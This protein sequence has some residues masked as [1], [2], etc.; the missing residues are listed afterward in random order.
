VLPPTPAGI[1]RV[2]F[3]AR[4]DTNTVSGANPAVGLDREGRVIRL[5]QFVTV[6][7]VLTPVLAG[8]A[9]AQPG[10]REWFAAGSDPK[11]YRMGPDQAVQREDEPSLTIQSLPAAGET[12]DSC[13]QC[14]G[15]YMRAESAAPWREK[16]VRFSAFVR[17]RGVAR[18]AGLWLRVDGPADAN[19]RAEMLAFDNMHGRPITGDTDWTRYEIVL[20][21]DEEATNLAYGLLLNGAGKAWMDGAMLEEVGEDVATTETKSGSCDPPPGWTCAGSRPA[22][23]EMGVDRTVRHAGSFSAFVRSREDAGGFGTLLQSVGAESYRGKRIRLSGWVRA[24][25]IEPGWAGLWLRVDG[26]ADE[27]GQ[28]EVLAF[29]NMGDRKITGTSDWTRHDIVLEVP[30]T[31]ESLFY[32]LLL[33]QTGQVWM[34]ELQIEVVTGDVPVTGTWRAQRPRNLDFEEE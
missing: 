34:D 15:T 4:P 13:P 33:Q 9:L 21:V 32:G 16:K 20:P 6:C 26:P 5:R 24:E 11:H 28:A 10:P 17:S 31:A 14:F 12:L 3:P 30:E 2:N 29:D 18:W 25:G 27:D 7:S 8:A 23:Y 1:P 19:G 22:D